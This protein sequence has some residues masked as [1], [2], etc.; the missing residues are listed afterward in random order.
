[1]RR[2]IKFIFSFIVIFLC[3]TSVG[4]AQKETSRFQYRP[5]AKFVKKS[6]K[7]GQPILY[8]LSF[9]HNPNQVVIFPDTLHDFNGF[10]CLGLNW[11]PTR[12]DSLGSL[13]SIVYTLQTFRLA[14]E[15]TLSLPVYVMDGTDSIV[16]RSNLDTLYLHRLIPE[17]PADSTYKAD[18]LII[19]VE[20]WIN[21]PYWIIG[22]G[23]ATIILLLLN[24][25][26]GRPFQKAIG[27]LDLYRRHLAFITN[28]DR[29]SR[30]SLRQQSPKLAG[31]ALIDW[32]GYLQKLKGIPFSTF[33]T[34]EMAN[35]LKDELLL[36]TL[37]QLDRCVYGGMKNE[38]NDNIFRVLRITALRFYKERQQEI[39]NG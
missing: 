9:R 17:N 33:S 3:Y 27:L 19:P 8:S 2:Q 35:H 1:M 10:D 24:T 13:D 22:S 34:K 23:L 21:Y 18:D 36:D 26:L 20:P 31:E 11:F 4:V 14:T 30:Q 15:Q 32:K 12:T 39:R 6:A 37:R 38:L 29:L 7:V 5:K 25:L 16:L 28:F